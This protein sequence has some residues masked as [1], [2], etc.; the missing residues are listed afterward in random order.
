VMVSDVVQ[1]AFLGSPAFH[2]GGGTDEIQ[3]NL[4]GERVLGLPK[5]PRSDKELP[6]SRSGR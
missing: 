1:R 2:I 3:K 4:I 5:D 6:F